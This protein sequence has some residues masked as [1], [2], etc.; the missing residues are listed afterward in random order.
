MCS[1]Y[2]GRCSRY[3]GCAQ[4]MVVCAQGMV[5]GAQGMVVG[6]DFCRV[7]QFRNCFIGVVYSSLVVCHNVEL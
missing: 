1:R 5:V 4:G 7:Q 2:G 6:A 3:G